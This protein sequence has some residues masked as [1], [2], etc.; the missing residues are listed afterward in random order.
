MAVLK[1]TSRNLSQYDSVQRQ[2]QNGH[3]PNTSLT[4]KRMHIYVRIF[5]QILINLQFL[6]MVGWMSACLFYCFRGK[7]FTKPVAKIT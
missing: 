5:G 6:N 7:A 2:I 1:I 3:L 4:A